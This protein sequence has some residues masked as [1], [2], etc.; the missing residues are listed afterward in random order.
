[1]VRSGVES[2]YTYDANDRLLA[3][4]DTTYT[5]DADGLLVS[6]TRAG[7]TTTYEWDVEN[8]LASVTGPT[9]S[10]RFAYDVD[11]NRV[12]R[13]TASELTHFIVDANNPTG[14]PQVLEER[15]VSD[16]L[17]AR[18]TYGTDLLA[19][20]RGAEVSSYQYDALGSARLLT[21]ADGAP[22]DTYDY[23]AF[24]N[25]AHASGSTANPYLFAGEQFESET[26]LYK[27][28]ARNYDPVSGRFLGRDPAPGRLQDPR[29]RHPFLYAH[30]D[31][32]N[33]TDPTGRFTLIEIG[34]VQGIQNV[35]RGLV[36]VA[37][38]AEKGCR[39]AGL[40]RGFGQA[41]LV[42]A[43][44]AAAL[45]AVEISDAVASKAITD[46]ADQSFGLP[47]AGLVLST[48]EARPKPSKVGRFGFEKS[49]FR[50]FYRPGQEFFLG[51]KNRTKLP[52]LRSPHI[53]GRP[54]VTIVLTVDA[55]SKG[56]KVRLRGSWERVS[57]TFGIDGGLNF[58]YPIGEVCGFEFAKLELAL[59]S[60]VSGGLLSG[61]VGFKGGLGLD[62]TILKLIKFQVP[63]LPP[64][65][66]DA[67]S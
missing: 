44:G 20:T 51:S 7:L 40:A 3:G 56:N 58:G 19:M 49:E 55:L 48:V 27:L 13:Q 29:S 37:K 24:G 4:G 21:D 59:R 22:T 41:G 43:T 17:R 53:E 23:D 46:V 28:R 47:R 57:D 39:M 54:E 38:N 31:P 36:D 52:V 9:G 15:S 50:L 64:G 62:I 45:A 2:L 67:G 12:R 65:R 42:L 26:G 16:G 35:L 1:M 63:V 10:A 25:L 34:L 18:Y 66:T 32:V 14:L 5:Y 30:C 6:Q 33:R 11:G 8:R 60:G 61:G